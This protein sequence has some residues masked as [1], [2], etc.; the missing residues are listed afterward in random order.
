MTQSLEAAARALNEALPADAEPVYWQWRRKANRWDVKLIFSHEVH[1]TTE[2]SEVRMLFASHP[3]PD[4]TQAQEPAAHV[5]A[6]ADALAALKELV[7]CKDLARQRDNATPVSVTIREE[8]WA[9]ADR[10]EAE[11]KR[12]EPL[13]WAEARRVIGEVK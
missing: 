1:P 6:Q 3:S 4:R 12:R 11:Y 5:A 13:A 9:E 2:D 7:A 8:D 10:L